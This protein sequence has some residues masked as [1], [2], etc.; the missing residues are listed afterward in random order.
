MTVCDQVQQ[1]A[2]RNWVFPRAALAYR[3]QALSFMTESP[4]SRRQLE[5]WLKFYTY[6]RRVFV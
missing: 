5:K 2:T 6:M 3:G 4:K 1:L